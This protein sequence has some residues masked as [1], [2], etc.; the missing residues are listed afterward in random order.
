MAFGGSGL[1]TLTLSRFDDPRLCPVEAILT[2]ISRSAGFRGHVH[3][4]FVIV[5]E[6]SKA[7]SMQSISRWTKLFFNKAGLGQFT[8]HSGRSASSSCALLLGM[9]IDA[10]LR[11]AG[12]K[13]KSSFVH[14]YMKHPLTAVTYKHGFSKVFGSKLGEH[15]TPSIDG[16]VQHFLA[17][18]EVDNVLCRNNQ[19]IGV[20]ISTSPTSLHPSQSSSTWTARQQLS[21]KSPPSGQGMTSHLVPQQQAQ[22]AGQLLP[23]PPMTRLCKHQPNPRYIKP[24]GHHTQ[25]S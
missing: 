13:S 17:Q 21:L 18:S 7:A 4:L 2:Y 19:N 12:W 25:S 20:I 22:T 24:R 6:C 11:H 9:P 14:R 15:V 1:Q 8:V 5:G 3:Q 10:I 23:M 16:R